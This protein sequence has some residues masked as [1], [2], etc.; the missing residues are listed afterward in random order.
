MTPLET[1]LRDRIAAEG[2]I[3]VADF[4]DAALGDPQY[5]YY[6]SRDP[7]GRA[8]DFITAPEISQVFGE[9]IG[10]WAAVTWQQIGAPHRIALVE[11]GPG[12]GTL[13]ADALRAARTVPAF[14]A[15]VEIH[16]V[17]TSPTLRAAQSEALATYRPV[18]HDSLG[19]LPAGPAVFIANEF[20]DALPVR[21]YEREEDG[22]YERRIATAAD[23]LA[24]SLSPAA[25]DVPLPASPPEPGDVFETCA[26]S[27]AIAEAIG[28]RIA[29]DGGA[30]LVVDYGHSESAYGDTLQAVRGHT[31][32]DPLADPGEADLTAHVD[33]EALATAFRS[34]GAATFGPVPQGEFL[35]SLGIAERTETLARGQ[36]PERAVLIRSATNRLI[37]S[38]QMGRLFKVLAV[39]GP[40]SPP[41]AGF[42][43]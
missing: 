20:F 23:G 38:R 33:F 15:A 6:R 2:P 35:V 21:Q 41:P 14:A 36:A 4:M 40:D 1:R 42:E 8:G 22:W 27:A 10:L 43:G 25:P 39:V 37:D 34:G 12:R 19:T 18:W 24:L 11:C 26:A 5:G 9:L 28:R 30:A 3:S 29:R 13:M 16:L 32:V 31:Y 17:E 7:L